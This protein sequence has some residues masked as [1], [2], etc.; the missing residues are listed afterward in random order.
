MKFSL[1]KKGNGKSQSEISRERER[2]GER[3]KAVIFEN[4]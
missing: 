4:E 1:S 2:K 3:E